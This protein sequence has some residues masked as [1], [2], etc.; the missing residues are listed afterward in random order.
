MSK[1][2]TGLQ[3]NIAGIF[4]GVPVPKKSGSRSQPGGPAPKPDDPASKPDGSVISKPVAQQPV[5]PKPKAPVTPMPE[6]PVGSIPA[7][8]RPKVVEIKVPEQEIRKI[9]KKISR[10]RKD[11]LFA[12]KPGANSSKQKTSIIVFV[13]LS[14]VLVVVLARPYLASRGNPATPRTDGKTNTGNSIMANIE[15]DWPVPTVYSAGPRDPMELG[16]PQQQ[17]IIEASDG[18]VVVG[19]S[20]S[21]DLKFVTIGIDLF[22]EGDIVPGT[23]IKVKKINRDS[24]EFE[25]DGKTWIQK[26]GERQ[27]IEGEKKIMQ[28]L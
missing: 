11:K 27:E 28:R 20:W 16:S 8:P 1:K 13:L 9:P 4:S 17:R 10:R 2:R 12:P 15:I 14:I 22:Q 19:I 23:K 24:V 3:S 21:E 26:T 7:A 25:E 18:L 5:T 6:R